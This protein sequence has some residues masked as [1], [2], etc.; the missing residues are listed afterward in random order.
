MP[1]PSLQS[2]ISTS[3][4]RVTGDIVYVFQLDGP[5]RLSSVDLAV[6]HDGIETTIVTSSARRLRAARRKHKVIEGP[7]TVIRLEISLSFGAPGFLAAA[8]TACAQAGVNAFLLST[9]SYDYLLV[10][11][12]DE[13]GALTALHDAGFPVVPSHGASSTPTGSPEP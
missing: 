9:F 7:F 6:I 5:V 10:P 11:A 8:T 12:E 3:P 13:A 1:E 4:A 2:V